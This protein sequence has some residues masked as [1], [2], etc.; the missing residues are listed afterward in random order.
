MAIRSSEVVGG[1]PGLF[2]WSTKYCKSRER[3][4]DDGMDLRS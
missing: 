4:G 2:V 3:D 1:E